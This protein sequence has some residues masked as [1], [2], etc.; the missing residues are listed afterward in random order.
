MV[1]GVKRAEKWLWGFVL[2]CHFLRGLRCEEGWHGS[3]D[4]FTPGSMQA[5]TNQRFK[6]DCTE[7]NHYGAHLPDPIKVR[8]GPHKIGEV[9][10]EWSRS[11]TLVHPVLLYVIHGLCLILRICCREEKCCRGGCTVTLLGTL[12]PQNQSYRHPDIS[13]L[14]IRSCRV[15]PVHHRVDLSSILAKPP[16][17]HS[18]VLKSK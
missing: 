11:H 4:G 10:E 15:R 9:T 18:L 8:A 2:P 3:V 5:Q 16:P 7:T 6:I 1:G 14:A 17:P 13:Q 12:N